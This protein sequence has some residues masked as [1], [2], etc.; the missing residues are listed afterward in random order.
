M[1]RSIVGRLVAKDLY[2]YRWLMVTALLA[3]VA[4]PQ[5]R[6]SAGAAGTRLQDD[7]ARQ[8]AGFTA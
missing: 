5:R 4:C 7:E 2:L 3:G 6:A 8:I 1:N